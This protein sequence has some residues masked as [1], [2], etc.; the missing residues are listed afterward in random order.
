MGIYMDT[1]K[2][3]LDM[4]FENE[5]SATILS[6]FLVLYGG[7]AAPKLPN[8]IIKLF[9]NSIFRLV[10]LSLVAYG[11]NKNPK[12]ALIIAL[13]FVITMGMVRHIDSIESFSDSD[14]DDD[15]DDDDGLKTE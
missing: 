13:A 4:I 14:L 9:N 10:I 7:L 6:L 1:V 15:V 12:V 2:K 8:F 3:Y 11:G 5:H